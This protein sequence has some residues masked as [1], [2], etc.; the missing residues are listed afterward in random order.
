MNKSDI[1]FYGAGTTIKKGEHTPDIY[2]YTTDEVISAEEISTAGLNASIPWRTYNFSNTD[3]QLILRENQYINLTK[4]DSLLNISLRN[5]QTDIT[6]E[7]TPVIAA[8]YKLAA[9]DSSSAVEVPLPK[10]SLDDANCS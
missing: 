2:K 4:G 3:A 5:T 6:N 8:S 1:A 7:F 9:K 10:L